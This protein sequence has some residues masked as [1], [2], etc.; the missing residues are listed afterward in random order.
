MFGVFSS[1][2]LQVLHDWIRGPAS[3][4]GRA[5]AEPAPSGAPRRRATFRALQRSAPAPV[6]SSADAALDPDLLLLR[7]RLAALDE[8]GRSELLVRAM[9]PAQHWT[10]AGLEATRAFWQAETR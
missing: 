4:D 8:P 2:E 5:Y 10:P 6:P 3:A 7:E 9:S 1:Y